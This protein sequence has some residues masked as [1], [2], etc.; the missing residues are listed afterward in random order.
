ML[1]APGV[2]KEEPISSSSPPPSASTTEG[3]AVASFSGLYEV[4]P[5][6]PLVKKSEYDEN[7][8]RKRLQGGPRPQL[9]WEVD[10]FA[11]SSLYTSEARK[12][13]YA[14]PSTITIADGTVVL[15]SV[16]LAG[17]DGD[18]TN[19]VNVNQDGD[20]EAAGGDLPPM[21]APQHFV[22]PPDSPSDAEDSDPLTAHLASLGFDSSSPSA[23]GSDPSPK[24]FGENIKKSSSVI[25]M[26]DIV[27]GAAAAESK[28]KDEERLLGNS[29]MANRT[30]GAKE[31]ENM[32]DICNSTNKV[33]AHPHAVE[34]KALTPESN[35]P[36]RE[37]VLQEIAS[38]EKGEYNFKPNRLKSFLKDEKHNNNNRNNNKRHLHFQNHHDAGKTML[39]LDVYFTSP[40]LDSKRPEL[41][42]CPEDVKTV[43]SAEDMKELVAE[44]I[45]E[46]FVAIDIEHHSQH[47]F[48]G[49]CCLLQISSKDHDWIV[50][51]MPVSGDLVPPETDESTTQNQKEHYA[52]LE[53]R[54]SITLLN[55]I[56]ANPDIV[57]VNFFF[58]IFEC[59]CSMGNQSPWPIM[60][61]IHGQ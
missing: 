4:D 5:D 49:F 54:K 38:F 30:S 36:S 50:D 43:K 6:C 14:T 44:L 60:L 3:A 45:T 57:K 25:A 37:R 2:K 9:Q 46:D 28:K 19:E 16:L 61:V 29:K 8:Q 52:F 33:P 13:F 26:S 48:R 47:S 35:W 11:L 53:F 1:S 55:K 23:S 18:H 20:Q 24:K 7:Y 59:S 51:L 10:N 41:Y 42:D 34:I 27:S 58:Q 15:D 40:C 56:T 17:Q 21:K 31:E 12:A 22:C 39:K 32:L